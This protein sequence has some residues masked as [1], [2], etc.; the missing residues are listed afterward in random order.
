MKKN[1]TI[2]RVFLAAIASVIFSFFFVVFFRTGQFYEV[3]DD[4]SG[5]ISRKDQLAVRDNLARLQYFYDLNKNLTPPGL[6]DFVSRHFFKDAQYYQSAYDQLTGNHE[7]VA[8]HDL[9]DDN[10]FWGSY[11]R[12]NSKWRIAQGIFEGSL[13]KNKDEKT[14]MA[15]QKQAIEM[16]ASTK[17]DYER[18][19]RLWLTVEDSWN[20][21]I[22]AD[23]SA[24]ARA[25][26]PKPI[27]VRVVLGEGG[28]KYKG[29]KGDKG[30]GPEGKGTLDLDKKGGDKPGQN[31]NPG[32]R[33][34]G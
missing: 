23:P 16:A 31:N 22:T 27:K 30:E 26:A 15:E 10:S 5:A 4:T 17:D 1:I 24:M 2:K 7:K 11:L 33:R 21:D 34:E 14:R 29:P 28:N 6:D 32:A 18:A 8:D 25:L 12:A 13:N 20:Y 19:I 3:L 9:K